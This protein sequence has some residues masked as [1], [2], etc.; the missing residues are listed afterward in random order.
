M[1]NRRLTFLLVA[2]YL[3]VACGPT[4]TPTPIPTPV[5]DPA[6]V[7]QAFLALWE[8]EQ[9]AEM[10]RVLSAPAAA[11]TGEES[12][13]SQ[14]RDVA[15]SASLT[16][17]R[18]RVTSLLVEGDKARAADHV[19]WQSATFGLI[20]HENVLPLTRVDG[21]WGID[22]NSQV[23][24]PGLGPY[25]TLQVLL[26]G[27]V[28]GN[29]YD[30]KDQA[31][32]SLGKLVTVGVVPAQIDDERS[33][34]AE[35]SRVLRLA[36]DAIKA[37]YEDAARP[38]WFMPVADLPPDPDEATLLGLAQLQGVELR[39]KPRRIYPLGGL[40]AHVIGYVGEISAEELAQWQDHGYQSGD[41]VGKSGLERWAEPQLAGQRGASLVVVTPGGQV[42]ATLANRP[43]VHSRN[44]VVTLDTGLQKAVEQILGDQVGA[45]V[46][47]DPRNGDV[48]AMASYPSFN[49][50][51]FATGIQASVWS[52]LANDPRSP[53]LNRA[54]QP[55][56]RPGSIFKVV[57]MAAGLE[58][59]GYVPSSQFTCLG[60]WTYL[61]RS[62]PCWVA[63]GHGQEDLVRGLTQSC[64]VV[65]FQI[66]AHLYDVS[67]QILPEMARAFGLGRQTGIEL[68]DEAPGLVPDAAWKRAT[69]NDPWMPYDMV[70][71][72]IG[73]GDLLVTPVQMAMLYGAVANGGTL[74]R[75]R[76]VA[77][78]PAWTAGE[79]DTVMPPQVIGKLPVAADNLAA[80]RQGLEGVTTPP[81]G[82]AADIFAGLAVKSA[83]KTGT[84]QS[85]DPAVATDAWY[86]GYAP[87][88][89]PEIVV[90]VIVEGKGYG[91]RFAAPMARKVI[92]AWLAA[93]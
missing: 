27:S 15:S 29:I 9:Y 5:N 57:T 74:Y 39:N 55:T 49:P 56:Y 81:Y 90:A 21:Q 83:G 12:F 63:G 77:N 76:L 84:P 23:I 64:N 54:T 2:S 42:G 69:R 66:G 24:L 4:P 28:R 53:L 14:Y 31:L 25:D 10:Y 18:A 72:A 62:W 73:E 46:V 47:L 79:Q 30:R 89:N 33:M 43:T 78:I 48:L 32:A 61:G 34:L 11:A 60:A 87:T 67:G 6:D 52:R 59:G 65:F 50:N 40:A 26:E 80:I 41:L 22:W 1:P 19:V 38:D 3:L 51:D 44:V 91:S 7:A 71:M 37:K 58:K 35:L 82:T 75:P 45:I 8:Q 68:P 16:S 36:P 88:E 13:T 20:Q 93:R 70:N 17:V 85:V 86:M 92:E